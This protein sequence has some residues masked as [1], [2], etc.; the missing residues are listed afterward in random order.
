VQVQLRKQAEQGE[1]LAEADRQITLLA[2][3]GAREAAVGAAR[4]LDED[5]RNIA[6]LAQVADEAVKTMNEV[7]D[8]ERRIAADDRNRE[9]RLIE[10][11]SRLL[12]G[13]RS[14]NRRGTESPSAP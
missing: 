8:I 3:K 12:E 7:L 11:K 2:S 10:I 9:T 4:S 5:P 13:M 1:R 6:V 14:V